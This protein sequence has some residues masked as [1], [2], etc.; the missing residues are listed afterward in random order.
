[1]NTDTNTH[2]KYFAMIPARDRTINPLTTDEQQSTKQ[3][4]YI[5]S[6][7]PSDDADWDMTFGRGKDETLLRP[8]GA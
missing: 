5:L 6:Y 2:H 3:V 1:M 8:V 4:K 7:L